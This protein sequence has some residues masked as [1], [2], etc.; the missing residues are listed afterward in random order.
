[1][2]AGAEAVAE[3]WVE[4]GPEGFVFGGLGFMVTHFSNGYIHPPYL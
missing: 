1:M 3:A 4:A 2:G